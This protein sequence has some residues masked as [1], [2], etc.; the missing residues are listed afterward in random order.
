MEG[1]GPLKCKHACKYIYIY[2]YIYN[3]NQLS[4]WE[5]ELKETLFVM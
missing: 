1:I 4:E 2:I 5:L 3:S